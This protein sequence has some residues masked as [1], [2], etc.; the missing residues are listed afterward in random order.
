[1]NRKISKVVKEPFSPMANF[2]NGFFLGLNEISAIWIA[3][4]KRRGQRLPN[5]S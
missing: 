2:W 3:S 4:G 5:M 1:M